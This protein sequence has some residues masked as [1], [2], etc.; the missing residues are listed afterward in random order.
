[1]TPNNLRCPGTYCPCKS[2]CQLAIHPAKN[3]IVTWAALYIR[4]T[5]DKNKCDMFVELC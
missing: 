5:P 1:M 3:E 4:R 2:L